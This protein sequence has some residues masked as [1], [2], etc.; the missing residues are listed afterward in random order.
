MFKKFSNKILSAIFIVLLVLTAL[1]VFIGERRGSRSFKSELTNVDTSRVSSMIIYPPVKGDKVQLVKSDGQWKVLSGD[2][3]YAAEKNQVEDMLQII[4]E[5]KANR[6]AARDKSKWEEYRVT[7]SLATRVQLL[8]GSKVLSDIYLGRFSYQQVPGANPYMGQP[9]KMTTYVRLAD[10]KEVYATEGM[11]AMTFNRSAN[12]FRNK[13]LIQLTRDKVKSLGF[14]TPE[15]DYRLEKANG[16]WMMSGL[17]AD[18]AQV[19]KYLSSISWLSS[20]GFLDRDKIL[21]DVAQYTLTIEEEGIQPVMIKAYPSDTTFL[22]AVESSINP[23]N[24]FNG[25]E[26]DLFTKIFPG[27]DYFMKKTDN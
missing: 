26:S 17:I 5:L 10:E 3:K 27:K 2:K 20:S 19:E 12:D 6:V 24:L 11:L 21:S 18:S 8:A 16:P 7:D 1:S 4:R 9:G 15:G 25:K 13:K 14:S 22:Y 23:E